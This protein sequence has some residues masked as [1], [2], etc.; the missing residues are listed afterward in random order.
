M[1]IELS[2]K[3]E[4]G[5]VKIKITSADM[6][7]VMETV[8]GKR[9]AGTA[10]PATSVQKEAA[11]SE[12]EANT[13][14]AGRNTVSALTE[15]IT[16]LNRE[17]ERIRKA[18]YRAKKKLADTVVPRVPES[19]PAPVPN[20][21]EAVPGD[22]VGQGT[23]NTAYRNTCNTKTI[24]K[25]NSVNSSDIPLSQ[26]NQFL[27]LATLPE[28][29]RNVVDAWNHLPLRSKLKGL[30]PDVAVKLRT[31]LEKYGEASLRKAIRMVAD[32]PFLL[33][34]SSHSSGWVICFSWL[35]KPGNL[36]KVLDNK[37]RN[38][39]QD[40]EQ[41]YYGA[42]FPDYSPWTDAETCYLDPC[43]MTEGLTTLNEHTQSCLEQAARTLGL[44][45]EAVA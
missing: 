8:T 21:P 9:S 16:S 28:A 33:G 32:S 23:E 5:V 35:L 4:N 29:Y 3:E 10:V 25:T 6:P 43:I 14:E 7:V 38:R 39:E 18:V 42:S 41:N 19:Y 34:K 31:T 22:N 12:T 24:T 20:V 1:N 27:P 2:V 15:K 11:T 40:W 36:Q 26:C 17:Y 13:L 37:Y 44:K 45:K 30:Y